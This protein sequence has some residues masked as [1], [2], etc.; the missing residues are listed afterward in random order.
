MPEL[1]NATIMFV[2]LMNSVSLSSSMTFFEYDKMIDEFQ[3]TMQDELEVVRRNLEVVESHIGGDQLCVFFYDPAEVEINRRVIETEGGG[4]G[5]DLA[6]ADR[7]TINRVREGFAYDALVLAI[8]IKNRWISH[9]IN[10]ERIVKFQP[11]LDLGIG[12]NAGKVILRKRYDGR[13]RIEGFAIN[14]AKRVEGFARSGHFSRIMVS[15]GFFDLIRNQVHSHVMLKQRLFFTRHVPEPGVLKGLPPNTS[16]YELKFFHRIGSLKIARETVAA[17]E[18]AFVA[19]PTNL[20]FYTL[21]IEYLLYHA[22]D[23]DKSRRIAETALNCN[24]ANEKIYFDLANICQKMGDADGAREYCRLALRLNHELDYAYE[25][26]ADME[27][28]DKAGNE[29]R[30]ELYTKALAVAPGSPANKFNLASALFE[31]G[32]TDEARKHMLDA[33]AI[34]PGYV[35][36][37]P[38]VADLAQKLGIHSPKSA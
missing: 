28:Q 23:Y 3:M 7:A 14:L 1:I 9:P 17:Y 13:V 16:V 15:K 21:L 24:P 6:E 20:W 35:K 31:V 10:V 19:D 37:D 2:D 29:R 22:K 30:V 34:F 33:V 4:G 26:L 12:I 8:L 38:D 32:R 11:Y 25:V 36:Q 5:S 27:P 18:R